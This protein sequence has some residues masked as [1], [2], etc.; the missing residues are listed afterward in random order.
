V[1]ERLAAAGRIILDTI[2]GFH[3]NQGALMAAGLA[4]YLLISASPLLIIAVAVVSAILGQEQAQMAM[5]ERL[6][7]VVGPDA[8]ASVSGLLQDVELFS[9]GMVASLIAIAALLYGS[10]RAFAALQGSFDVI[11]ESQS[12]STI[13]QG[14]LLVVRSR[15][16][17]FLMVVAVGVL[18]LTT[19]AIQTAGA[20]LATWIERYLSVDREIWSIGN[21]VALLVVRTLALVAVYRWLP[22]RKIAWRDAWAA[23]LLSVV[24]LRF[25]HLLIAAYV[26]YGGAYS[27]Y[28]AAGSIIVL[29]FAFYFGAFVVLLGAQFAKAWSDHRAVTA[30][31]RG[32]K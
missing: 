17:A 6:E 15:L 19:V 9:G 31:R 14:I 25:G 30:G 28:T 22:S 2:A 3:K 1:T 32:L 23:A 24:L 16:I 10:T 11:W 13:R 20:G 5:H 4:Y 29:L 8:A 27:A 18:F 12:S 26:D 21:P 7:G